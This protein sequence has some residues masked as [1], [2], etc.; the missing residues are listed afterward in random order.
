MGPATR[1][2]PLRCHATRLT[3]REPG[4]REPEIRGSAHKAAPGSASY[5]GLENRRAGVQAGRAA[6]PLRRSG[7]EGAD[8]DQV[9]AKIPC[10]H[11]IEAPFLPSRRVRSQP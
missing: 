10:P 3:H 7:G 11:Q 9:A 1:Q 5:S 4:S 6:V 8:L 2:P